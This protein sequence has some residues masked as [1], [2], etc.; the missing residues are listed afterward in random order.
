MDDGTTPV[1][2]AFVF[3]SATPGNGVGGY[4]DENG[5][6]K[7][8][9]SPGIT[10]NLVVLGP[11][12]YTG[13]SVVQTTPRLPLSFRLN[14]TINVAEDTTVD[15]TLPE[16][17]TVT[18]TTLDEENQNPVAAAKLLAQSVNGDSTR[19]SLSKNDWRP[20]ALLEPLAGSYCSYLLPN[21]ISAPAASSAD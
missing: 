21:P 17:N 7:L 15:L 8:Q 10:G 2:N 20:S 12:R 5:F 1:E 13:N 6:Y 19:C 16:F 11:T 9:A 18:V 14:G 3:W 4:T